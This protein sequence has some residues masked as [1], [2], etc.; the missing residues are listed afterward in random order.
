MRLREQVNAELK[1]RRYVVYTLLTLS[2]LYVALNL[3]FGETGIMRYMEFETKEAALRKEMKE[4][5][6][7]REAL[8]KSITTYRENEFYR[9]KNARENFG[10]AGSDEY[11]FLYE[12]GP[13]APPRPPK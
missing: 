3:T 4:L 5:T 1:L 9:E 11:I 7:K 8:R 12:G 10:F 6:E 2:L 13:A